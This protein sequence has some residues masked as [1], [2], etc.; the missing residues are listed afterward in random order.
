M[1]RQ[2]PGISGEM[3]PVTRGE[4]RQFY[5]CA[6]VGWGLAAVLFTAYGIWKKSL[7]MEET[8]LL[9][10]FMVVWSW[11]FWLYEGYRSRK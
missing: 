1:N 3:G 5:F 9:G 8:A 4:R 10:L 7:H 2:N 11:G 6:A